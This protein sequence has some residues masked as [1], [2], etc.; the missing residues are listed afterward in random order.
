MIRFDRLERLESWYRKPLPPAIT[1]EMLANALDICLQYPSAQSS[2][3]IR[4]DKFERLD[5]ENT[6]AKF[7]IVER[8]MPP[9][10]K[11]TAFDEKLIFDARIAVALDDHVPALAPYMMLDAEAARAVMFEVNI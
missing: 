2:L 10:S 4:Y 3:L 7:D 11:E 8:G 1:F 6:F 9:V 5:A